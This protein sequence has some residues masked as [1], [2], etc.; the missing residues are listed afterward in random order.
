MLLPLFP[1]KKLS[2][3]LLCVSAPL[4]VFSS[5]VV[6]LATPHLIAQVSASNI[7]RPI[8]RI[9]SQGSVVS[10]LQAALKLLGFFT[11]AVDGVYKESTVIAVSRFQQ[12]AG[13]NP[14]G[15]VGSTTWAKLFPSIPSATASAPAASNTATAT[16]SPSPTANRSAASNTDT[17]ASNTPRSNR[18]RQAANPAP[19]TP[20]RTQTRTQR[21]QTTRQQT[22]RQPATRTAPQGQPSSTEQPIL[23]LGMRGPAVSQLQQR[24][25]RLGLFQGGIDGDFGPATEA[26]VKAA[27]Q[28]FRLD[29]DGVVGPSTWNAISQPRRRRGQARQGRQGN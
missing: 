29:P 13:L 19:A 18:R 11:G 3:L 23:R 9:G 22:T 26:A 17:T 14:D 15:V 28:R 27:Q 12:A 6:S 24:L 20:T 2:W 4:L 1:A 16:P 21:Q 5:A 8:L 25:Q 7:N 10:E